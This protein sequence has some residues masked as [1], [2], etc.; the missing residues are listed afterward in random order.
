MISPRITAVEL[1]PLDLP[2]RQPFVTALGDKRVSRNLL[3]RLRL[4]DGTVGI[5]E[6]SASLAWPSET[7]AAMA[8]ALRRL[9]GR[10][11]GAPI[12]RFR[13][14]SELAWEI[15]GA[16]PTAVGALECALMDAYTRTKGVSLWRFYGSRRRSVT[17]ALTL[18]AWAEPQAARAAANAHAAGFRRL[19]VKVTGKNPDEDLRRIAAVCKAAPKAILWVDGNQ[20][21]AVKEAIRLARIL[22]QKKFPIQLFEQPV[23]RENWDGLAQVQKEGGIPVAADESART[24]SEASWLIRKKTVQ[25]LNVKLAKSGLLGASEIVRRAKRAGMKLMIG[26]MAESAVGLSAS[27]HFAC[28]TGAFDFVDLDSHL[29]VASSDDAAGFQTRGARLTVYPA[30]PGCG[31]RV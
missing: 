19:K 5:G 24:V 26:C 3:V 22:R 6:A 14:L 7:Q 23:R 1:A 9:E 13:R 25:I 11:I 15:A 28:G 10:L 17:T 27:V 29:L 2:M 16:H 12:R 31:A 4:D 8:A 21:F 20:G 30:R 18:S